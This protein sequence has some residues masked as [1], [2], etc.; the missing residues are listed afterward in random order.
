MGSVGS[1]FRF[2]YIVQYYRAVL[3]QVAKEHLKELPK[4]CQN[5]MEKLPISG[6]DHIRLDLR[7]C[8]MPLTL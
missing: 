8:T 6:R 3:I 2:L 4:K 1:V 7:N 5:D